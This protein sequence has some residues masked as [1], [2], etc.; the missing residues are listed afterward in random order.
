[1]PTVGF[2]K[3]VQNYAVHVLGDFILVIDVVVVQ[4]DQE[5]HQHPSEILEAVRILKS[6]NSRKQSPQLPEVGE[7]VD[8]WDLFLHE[9]DNN[10]VDNL[11][12]IVNQRV[13]VS[14]FIRLLNLML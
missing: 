9:W 7:D 2:L 11:H 8:D 4:V 5:I 1:V 10:T 13:A 14:R 6:F 3:D 12:V